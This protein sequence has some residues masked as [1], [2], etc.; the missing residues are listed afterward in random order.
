MTSGFVRSTPRS[1]APVLSFLKS[2]RRQFFPPSVVLY[3]PRSA[4]GTLYLP[5]TATHATSGLVGCTRIFEIASTPAKPTCVHV[6]PPSP[7]RYTPSPGM[8]LPRMQLSPIPMYTT[9][10]F[11]SLTATAPTEALRICPSVTGRHV[12]PPS[13]VFHSPPPVAPKYASF[14]RPFTPATAIDRPP[15]SGPRLR[16]R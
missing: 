16:Q 2:T 15:R 12:S 7:L 4:L 3:T 11:D 9:S 1:T 8:M 5:N 13:V 6:F 10:G 14:R